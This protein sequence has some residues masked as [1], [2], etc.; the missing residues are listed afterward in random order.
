V[1][2]VAQRLEQ[3]PELRI[4]VRDGIAAVVGEPEDVHSKRVTAGGRTQEE[5]VIA[6]R[7]VELEGECTGRGE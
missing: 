1:E 6:L 3:I 2:P 7:D 4:E 5:R